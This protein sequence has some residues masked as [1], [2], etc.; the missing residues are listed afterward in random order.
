MLITFLACISS[1]NNLNEKW[2]LFSAI[3]L[4]RRPIITPELNEIEREFKQLL[5][6][7]EHEKSLKSNY[8]VRHE[9]EK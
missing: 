5:S 7:L 6:D 2:D 3:C 8:E 1:G 9:T 4:E